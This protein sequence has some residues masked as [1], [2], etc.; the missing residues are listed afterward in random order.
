MHTV[1]KINEVRKGHIEA[2]KWKTEKGLSYT[3]NIEYTQN[4]NQK[5]KKLFMIDNEPELI[6]QVLK[7]IIK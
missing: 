4:N 2:V 3:L 5:K 7:E 1:E 6:I